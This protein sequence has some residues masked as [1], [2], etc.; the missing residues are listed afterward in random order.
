MTMTE[1]ETLEPTLQNVLDQ[2][3]LKWIF[4]GGKGGVGKTTT[5]CSLAI[6][7]ASVRESVLLISTDPAH[8][9]SD[10]FGQKFSKDATKVNGFDN[11]YAMEIDPTSS[12]QEMIEQSDQNGMM[13]NMMQDLAFAIPGVD[14]AM[15]FAEIMKHVKSMEFSVI[16]FDTAPTG[17]TLRFLSFPS[18]LEKALGKLSSLGSRFGPMINQMSSMMG[19]QPGTQEDMFAKLDSMREVIS[20][21]NSQFKDPEKTTFVCVCISEFLSLYETERLV[22]E[23]ESYEIDTHNIVINQ[24]LFPKKGSNCEHCLVRYKM[25]QKYL[26][27]AHELYDEYFHI[28]RLPLLTEEVR[29][30][31]KLKEFSKMLVVPYV[32]ESE[33]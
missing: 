18:V 30:P 5:S 27:E 2:K 21:V 12:L 15:G 23:L 4:C 28:I 11:L 20:E 25:Q 6:Q 10:A 13:G 33:R 14:E 9:L 31:E 3:T 17:H 8:N 19:G 26:N 7:L 32:P 29:G 1:V 22:Q 16:V 24:L